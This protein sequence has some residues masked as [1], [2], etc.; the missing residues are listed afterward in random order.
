MFALCP[1]KNNTA[2]QKTVK[3]SNAQI[4][5]Y[6][7]ASQEHSE[8]SVRQ[9]FTAMYTK[10]ESTKQ[11]T[12]K[13]IPRPTLK[14][15]AEAG[16]PR[17]SMANEIRPNRHSGGREY[18]KMAGHP[19]VEDEPEEGQFTSTG[20]SEVEPRSRVQALSPSN[21]ANTSNPATFV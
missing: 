2:M 6:T 17:R 15:L 16:A 21:P 12:V 11:K 13:M 5:I 14:Q 10:R 3:N 8:W 9:F 20:S 4:D 1:A 18:A 7:A 19:P